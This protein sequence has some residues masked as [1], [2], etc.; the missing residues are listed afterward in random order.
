MSHPEKQ[1]L[2]Y[3]ENLLIPQ[4]ESHTGEEGSQTWQVTSQ[5]TKD[6]TIWKSLKYV[7]N[8]LRNISNMSEVSPSVGNVVKQ[9]K[10]GLIWLRRLT[11]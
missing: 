11:Q 7:K 2:K 3:K 9:V 1:T 10:K 8:F 5:V 4:E 6:H